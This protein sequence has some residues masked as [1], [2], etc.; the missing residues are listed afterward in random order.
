MIAFYISL[1]VVGAIAAGS[2]A[3]DR[4]FKRNRKSGD[5]HTNSE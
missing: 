5:R 4:W 3:L 2:I 1:V